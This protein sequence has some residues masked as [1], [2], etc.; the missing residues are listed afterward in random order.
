MD[1]SQVFSRMP[2]IPLPMAVAG[3]G[4]RIVDAEGKRYLDACGGA[5]VSCLG[6]SARPVIEAVKAQLDRMGF[7]HTAFFTSEPAEE[8]ADLLV[9]R[10]PEG[11]E[12]VYFLSGGSE[13]IEAALKLARQYHLEVG[14]PQR[15]YIVAREQSYHGNTLGALSAG[16]NQ[17]RRQPFEPLLS[18]AMRH[19]QSCHYW[20]Y[21]EPGESPEDYGRR[22]ADALETEILALGA[23]KV[24]A[25]IAEPV[26]GATLGAV[27]AAPG[28]FKRIREICDRYGVLLILDEV[29]CGMGRTGSL[30]ASEQEGIAP[31]IVCIAKGLGAG[32]QPIGA[33]LASGKI[34]DAVTGGS[35]FFQHGHTY[36]GHPA[37]CAAGVAVLKEIEAQDLLPGVRAQ[38]ASLLAAL[39]ERLG[40]HSHIGEVRGRGLFLGVELVEDRESKAPLDPARKIAARIKAEAMADGLMCY[41]MGGSLDGRRGDHV[42]LAPPFIVEEAD[43]EEIVDKLARAIDRALAANAG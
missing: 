18:P 27:A 35:G 8:L 31:D 43:L 2:R 12:R 40:D 20:R 21:G 16:G 32:L 25:F 3:E 28:Y 42:L 38:G 5:A 33:M 19:I 14:Q 34:Y 26:V 41:P 17:W 6:H 15:S 39:R 37:A 1:G 36:V 23:D 24:A 10:A 9:Q 22:A 30:F 13:A 4:C 29:M 11:I 7:A